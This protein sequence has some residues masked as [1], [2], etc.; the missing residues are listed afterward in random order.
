MEE[1]LKNKYVRMSVLIS[2]LSIPEDDEGAENA[3]KGKTPAELSREMDLPA[4]QV[5]N[6]LMFLLANP[7]LRNCFGGSMEELVKIIS[8]LDKPEEGWENIPIPFHFDSLFYEEE[9]P[10]FLKPMER[11]LVNG[12]LHEGSPLNEM[13]IIKQLPETLNPQQDTYNVESW[14]QQAID[15]GKGVA[16]TTNFGR[17]EAPLFP[18]RILHTTSNNLNYA[19]FYRKPEDEMDEPQEYSRSIYFL[20]RLDYIE[21][22]RI[23]ANEKMPEMN[24]RMKDELERFDYIWGADVKPEDEPADVK[25]KIYAETNN[26]LS[27]IK[28]DIVNRKYGKLTPSETEENVYYYTDKVIGMD[29]FRGWLFSYGNSVV[30]LEPKE[31][32]ERI[33]TSAERKLQFYREG[34]FTREEK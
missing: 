2:H 34:K 31:L 26:I 7:A 25:V 14:I 9:C 13:L 24:K 32:A 3:K 1:Y 21:K 10:I 19:V 29:S 12:V 20:R 15:D 33:C 22:V 18:V 4:A 5:R 8:A 30:V 27:K 6:D 16:I 17:T 28:A 11:S 23:L